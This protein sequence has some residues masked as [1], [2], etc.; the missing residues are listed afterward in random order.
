MTEN[1]N[2]KQQLWCACNINPER[3]PL[4][5]SADESP[6]RSS[7]LLPSLWQELR[8]EAGPEG[9]HGPAQRPQALR[10]RALRQGLRPPAFPA[11][12]PPATLQPQGS[13]AACQGTSRFLLF[14]QTL[15][16]WTAALTAF[17]SGHKLHEQTIVDGHILEVAILFRKEL[18]CRLWKCFNIFNYP[19]A[20][21]K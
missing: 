4:C 21:F 17:M 1:Q 8:P 3:W 10:V 7:L 6:W 2:R 20:E 14:C 19:T 15:S 13:H 11:H 16:P 12:P 9:A 18:K 5:W